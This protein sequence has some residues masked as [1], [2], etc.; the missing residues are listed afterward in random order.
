MNSDVRGVALIL[1]PKLSQAASMLNCTKETPTATD[2]ILVTGPRT[3][4]VRTPDEATVAVY[5]PRQTA[6]EGSPSAVVSQLEPIETLCSDIKTVVQASPFTSR[7]T[8]Q[9]EATTPV[10]ETVPYELHL[11]RETSRA[12]E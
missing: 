8:L 4:T 10:E 9:F 12:Q 2:R 1:A 5:A 6:I 3:H 7:T 11:V